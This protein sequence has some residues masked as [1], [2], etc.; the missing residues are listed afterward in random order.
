M[1]RRKILIA[2]DEPLIRHFL[3]EILTR[4][5]YDV[6][7]AKDGNIA[8][9]LLEK[10][11]F[12][13]I[14]TDMKMPHKDGME[15]LQYVKNTKKTPTVV[16]IMTAF[17]SVE[18]AVEA[19]KHGAFNYLIKPFSPETIE[20]IIEKADEH[21]SLIK[22][23]EFFLNEMKSSY[24]IIAKSFQIKKILENVKN[25]AKSNAS[26]FISG[27]SGTGKEVIAQAI[28]SNSLRSH[29]PFVKVN[30]A[31][32]PESLIESEF[33][34]YEKG[35]FTG[36]E[37]RKEGRFEI[38]HKGTILLDEITEIPILLQ[39]KLLRAIQ[40]QEF[41]R[42]GGIK[43]IK[44][45]VRIISTT[46]RKIKDVIDKNYFRED[47]F[48]RLNVIPIHLPPLRERKDDIIPLAEHFLNHFCIENHKKKKQLSFKAK[49]KLLNYFWPG[50]V[51]ELCNIIERTVVMDKEEIVEDYHIHLDT[52]QGE[53]PLEKPPIDNFIGTTLAE[54]EKQLILATLKKEKNNRT[55]TAKTLGLNIRT[56]R[57]KLNKY[58]IEKVL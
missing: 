53:S 33:F 55:R 48:Y 10:D 58:K 50:N 51:R 42:V 46:N 16:I 14:I 24:P 47:L 27:E 30:C 15:V 17:A 34:G 13:L 31:A 32:I 6:T 45:D 40:E 49:N 54:A 4:K 35:A 23:N 28:H 21:L 18:N 3:K 38:A 26:V 29:K 2:D 11:N 5:N 37:I 9:S 44:T 56:L 43:S 8:I 36:A 39:P 7:T 20:T 22:E 52:F 57:N 41:E 12:D 1:S 25:I 19:M